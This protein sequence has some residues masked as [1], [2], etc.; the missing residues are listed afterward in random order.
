MLL[1]IAVLVV[2]CDSSHQSPSRSSTPTPTPTGPVAVREPTGPP[3]PAFPDGS[4]TGWSHTGVTLR[5]S[6]AI[7]VTQDGAV[8][9][10]LDIVGNLVIKAN[11]VTVQRSRVTAGGFWPVSVAAGVTGFTLIDSEVVGVQKSPNVC[12]VGV[13]GANMTLIRVD[14]H[15]CEDGVHPGSDTTIRDSYIHDLWLGTN[16][17]GVRVVPTHND[18]IQVMGARH[19]TIEHNRIETGHNQNSAVFLKADFS[20]IDD[21]RVVGNYVDGGS[22]AVYGEDT[23]KG[24]VTNVVVS[25]NTFGTSSLYG[26]MTTARWTG[27]TVV[28]GNVTTA[29]KSLPDESGPARRVV[30]SAPPGGSASP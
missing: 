11:D 12:N 5:P 10:G 8:L 18:G 20:P 21:V 1:A 9:D 19:V 28:R 15:N 6:P 27:P 25:G 17:A 4:S 23:A 13:T 30:I 16:A 26:A 2:A 22:F 29:G 3:L 24:K 7:T 14:I